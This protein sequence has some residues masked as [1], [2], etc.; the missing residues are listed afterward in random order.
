MKN[1][2]QNLF[3]NSAR[4]FFMATLVFTLLSFSGQA[5]GAAAINTP[6]VNLGQAAGYVILAES[7]ITNVPTSKIVGNLGLYPGTSVTGFALTLASTGTYF[8]SPQVIG[9][10]KTSGNT[11]PTPANLL[12]AVNNML[13]AYTNANGRPISGPSYLNVGGG[14]IT[15]KTLAP[16]VYK[17]GTGVNASGKVYLQGGVNAVWIFQEYL[18]WRQVQKLSSLVAQ[19]LHTSSG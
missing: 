17:W 6:T 4:L 7:T 11:S 15:G 12:L 3:S 14:N 2:R 10:V 16:G 13:T 19:Y 9:K 1:A 18:I 5:A 8:K